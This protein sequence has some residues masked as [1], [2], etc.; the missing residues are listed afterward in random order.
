MAKANFPQYHRDR[1]Y[2]SVPCACSIGNNDLL[3]KTFILYFLKKFYLCRVKGLPINKT[4]YEV[5]K[6]SPTMR[7][8]VKS[9]IPLSPRTNFG[10]KSS[11][12]KLTQTWNDQ[13][14]S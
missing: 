1:S 9:D 12:K 7:I 6:E 3:F 5:T 11:R 2:Y 14:Y 8:T 4:A 13:R 10:N